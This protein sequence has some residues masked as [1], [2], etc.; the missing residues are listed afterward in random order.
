M[1]IPAARKVVPNDKIDDAI[2]NELNKQFT[3][4]KSLE[5]ITKDNIK[6]KCS[7]SLLIQ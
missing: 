1:T 6:K 4:Y 2:K 3:D 5:P 7:N